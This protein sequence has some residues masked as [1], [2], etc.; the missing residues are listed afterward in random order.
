[1][2]EKRKQI[3]IILFY[4][5]IL[6]E[7]AASFT[8]YAFGGYGELK[9]ILVGMVCFSLSICLD[10]ELKKMWPYYGIAALIGGGAYYVQKSALVLRIFLPL[11][12]G[13]KRSARTVAKIFFLGTLVVTV[14]LAILSYSGYGYAFSVSDVFRHEEELRYKFGYIH[15]NAF[16][17]FWFRIMALGLYAFLPTKGAKEVQED[18]AVF[19][20]KNPHRFVVYGV[21]VLFLIP[22]YFAGSKSGLVAGVLT[23]IG[24]LIVDL[25]SKDWV[26]KAVY[27]AGN[28]AM[29]FEIFA[30]YSSMTWFN[31]YYLHDE[32]WV[33]IWWKISFL[34]TGRN[35]MIW[36]LYHDEHKPPLLGAPYIGEG[37]EV[38]FV[39][40]LYNE[41]VILTIIYILVLFFAFY[42]MYK[43]KNSAGMI[44]I[45][46]F[47]L[48]AASERF[49]SY[50]NKN[51]VWMMLLGLC[52]TSE[53]KKDGEQHESSSS[54]GFI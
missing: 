11:L 23:I 15:P 39:N 38:G 31:L 4:L 8:G 26:R 12:A 2:Q 35:H 19:T 41:G 37:T 34:T 53:C 28:I 14:C 3:S 45:L 36:M 18:F 25:A 33:N 24:F 30:I 17:F 6:C 10:L 54:N 50:F 1:M 5:G 7:F 13:R 43:R 9:I 40:A 44:V 29:A 47:T 32:K 42:L 48:Y 46:A 49:L 27:I 16:S 51:A 21:S 52:L 20:K 22:L